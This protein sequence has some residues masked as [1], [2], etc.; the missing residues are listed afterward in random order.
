[1]WGARAA[2]SCS[3]TDEADMRVVV[4]AA[5]RISRSARA[6]RAPRRASRH[7]VMN[8]PLSSPVCPGEVTVECTVGATGVSAA[9]ALLPVM[10]C[11]AVSTGE[12]K[13][14]GMAQ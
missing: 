1:M 2:R 5:N 14:S 6:T 9:S 7:P 13:A 10:S 4:P 8:F 12:I 3:E 11:L